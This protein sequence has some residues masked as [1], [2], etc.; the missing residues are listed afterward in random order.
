[1]AYSANV[2][3]VMLAS[4][5]DVME[6][7]DAAT[8]IILDW[9]N[10]NSTVRKIVLMP[11]RW[12]SNAIPTMGE[13]PQEVINK[14][15]LE[16]A[17]LLIGIFWT[18]IGTPT[19]KALSGSVEEIEKHINSGKPTMLYFSDKPVIP[20]SI[21]S[22][23]YKALTKLKKVYQKKGVIQSFDSLLDF[24]NKFSRHL[25]MKINDINNFKGYEV[26]DQ[27]LDFEEYN[28]T[29]LVNLLSSHAKELLIEASKDPNGTVIKTRSLDGLNI[30]TNRRSFTRNGT[31]REEALWESALNELIE[32][33][34]IKDLGY[35]GEVFRLTNNGYQL[36]DNLSSQ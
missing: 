7:R 31:A 25:S 18:R 34:L 17:D 36:A 23:Q 9:N 22:K 6:E 35:K 29:D 16:N 5:S 3:N 2:Y 11:I 20:N 1:M 10:V 4:P 33:M 21:D 27:S 26:V 14:Q 19:G 30:Q 24:R 28:G 13:H 12:E 15:L 32:N 8:E